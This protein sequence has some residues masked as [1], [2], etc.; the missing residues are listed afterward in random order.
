MPIALQTALTGQT[1]YAVRMTFENS[2]TQVAGSPF[3][4]PEFLPG[5]YRAN[6]AQTDVFAD[7]LYR[8][9]FIKGGAPLSPPV[10]D[11]YQLRGGQ[12]AALAPV[13]TDAASRAASQND[14]SLI[15]TTAQVNA[16]RDAVIAAPA[17]T[18]GDR[19]TLTALST[20]ASEE[21]LINLETVARDATA[22]TYRATGF[23]T[24]AQVTAVTTAV[25][26]ARDN[27]NANTN[28]ARDTIISTPAF[29][30]DD[31]ATLDGI[32]T[33]A[34]EVRLANLETV[35]RDS[36]ASTY[37]ATGFSTPAQV[38]AVTT[39][40][41]NARDAV[42]TQGNNAWITATGFATVNPDNLTL[43]RL[44]GLL[45]GD[46]TRFTTTAL[47]NAPAGGGS[48]GGLTT[49]QN[50][51]LFAIPTNPLLASNYV[52]PNNAGISAIG[53]AVAAI[54]TTPLLASAYTAPDNASAQSAAQS[55]ATIESRLTSTRAAKLDTV[56]LTSNLTTTQNAILTQGND[57]WT[58]ATAAELGLPAIAT[59]IAAIPI[60]TLASGD[61]ALIATA[62]KATLDAQLN[63]IIDLEE[64]DVV[65]TL[66][67]YVKN[68]RGTQTA[69]FP[70]KTVSA[71]GDNVSIRQF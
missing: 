44:G 31:R 60:Q 23:A 39:A 5:L 70:S 1:D 46:F 57:A 17:F 69:L 38:T 26:N 2:T 65:K 56:A 24:P 27:V 4:A 7:G 14:L 55:A 47:S 43:S 30:T 51:Q 64:A 3:A 18:T 21:R 40:V 53:T 13:T 71:S 49:E 48:S 11:T 62:V 9:E 8:L 42:I 66:T 35:A 6:P 12:E 32:A 33:R 54:P 28:T 15:A 45:T 63:K 19:A 61:P 16:A 22:A 68:R 25:N 10:Y 50:T 34:S 20:R 37:R 29:T 59:A 36:T 41:N 67:T 58:T 52:A